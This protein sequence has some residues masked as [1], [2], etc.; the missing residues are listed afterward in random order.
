MARK[1]KDKV[2]IDYP[3]LPM[4]LP[5]VVNPESEIEIPRLPYP[6]W[7][8]NKARFIEEYLYRFVM[9]T[10]HGAYIDGF[11]GPQYTN[12]L[13]MWAA[14]LVLESE[15]PWLRHF[16][17]CEKRKNKLKAL[18]QLKQSLPKVDSRGRKINRKIEIYPGDSNKRIQEILKSGVISQK[19]A[20]FCLLDQHTFEC[21][22][23]T[24]QALANY[25]TADHNKIEI[26][27]FL[28]IKWLKRA[29][30]L[31]KNPEPAMNWWGR[32]DVDELRN[33][34]PDEIKGEF[35][36][37]MKSDLGYKSAHA[38]PIFK[39]K[40][41]EGGIMYYM[42]HASDHPEAH[43]LMRRAYESAV[44]PK[45]KAEQLEMWSLFEQ[46]QEHA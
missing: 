24:V 42:I 44:K 21:K 30:A 15:P 4:E 11:A 18:E 32:D 12:R 8:E 5:E 3:Y 39:R 38:W 7:T 14:K 13:D 26:F 34:K 19:E 17:L 25:K 28:A 36:R 29:L 22:W 40:G 16:Y 33:M 35:V 1:K 10:R 41:G 27:Y 45:D 20:T 31:L 37:R 2:P 46:S 23:A 6:V 9:V 43:K